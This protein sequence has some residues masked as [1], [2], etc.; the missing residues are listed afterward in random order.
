M[1]STRRAYFIIN[2]GTKQAPY[3]SSPPYKWMGSMGGH[4]VSGEHPI[5]AAA[6]MIINCGDCIS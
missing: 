6:G 1:Y 2:F 3:Y 4:G 5:H